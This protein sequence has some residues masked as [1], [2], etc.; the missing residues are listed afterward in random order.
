[1]T[2]S[3][4]AQR[5]W[6]LQ[7]LVDTWDGFVTQFTALWDDAVKAGEGEFS[8]AALYGPKAVDGGKALQV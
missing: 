3:R 8:A 4:A 1:M 6:L 2:D 7:A 5:S